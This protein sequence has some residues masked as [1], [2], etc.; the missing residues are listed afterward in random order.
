MSCWIYNGAPLSDSVVFTTPTVRA[1]ICATQITHRQA[2]WSE[3]LQRFKLKWKYQPGRV[4]VADPLSCR[5]DLVASP[6]TET[7]AELT[8]YIGTADQ[9]AR[10]K[11]AAV[12]GN[13]GIAGPSVRCEEAAVPGIP[14]EQLCTHRKKYGF[15]LASQHSGLVP[16]IDLT[17]LVKNAYY[18]GDVFA[19][20]E[21]VHSRYKDALYDYPL[22]Y[23]LMGRLIVPTVRTQT[24]I[25]RLRPFF[26]WRHGRLALGKMVRELVRA[27]LSWQVAKGFDH[28]IAGVAQPLKVPEGPWL[29]VSMD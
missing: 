15:V 4:N 13:P 29:S 16:T 26:T 9:S 12:S 20:E 11:E 3:Y 5:P 19:D 1:F 2:K 10:C 28:H 17:T 8:D 25:N 18:E 21:S 23:D 22:L 24:T 7:S 27:P 6:L 14:S